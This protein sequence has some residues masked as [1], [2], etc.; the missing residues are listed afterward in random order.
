M[1]NPWSLYEDLIDLVPG[2]LR[3]TSAV[4]SH[5]AAVTDDSGG[6]GVSMVYRGGPHERIDRDFV[7]RP[8]RDL[9]AQVCSWDLGL[10]SLG[11]AALNCALT[12]PTRLDACEEYPRRDAVQS[13]FDLYADQIAGRTVGVIGHFGRMRMPQPGRE[14]DGAGAQAGA[15][16]QLYVF[17]RRPSGADLPDSAAEYLL[18]QCDLVFITGSTV[19]NKTLPRL[20]HL[21]RDASVVLVGP[22]T[23][24]APEVF[25]GAVQGIGGSLIDDAVGLVSQVS[26]GATLSDLRPAM[27]QFNV[28][29][30][31]STHA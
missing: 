9:A 31:A 30:R 11:A 17:E 19:I 2:D 22:S 13:T 10:A 27:R 5:W 18:P 4:F 28:M 1:S 25:A 12:T 23:P 6:A 21:A 7:G 3:V 24:L 15:P 14:V 16:A 20:L 26:A 8:L 29:L